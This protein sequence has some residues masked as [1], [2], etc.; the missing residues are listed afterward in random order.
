MFDKNRPLSNLKNA[1]LRDRTLFNIGDAAKKVKKDLSVPSVDE[2]YAAVR[3]LDAD[4][5]EDDVMSLTYTREQL[6][7]VC[8]DLFQEFR[9][10]F[11]GFLESVGLEGKMN[12]RKRWRALRW[13]AARWLAAARACR[14]SRRF[15]RRSCGITSIRYPVEK[16]RGILDTRAS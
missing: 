6:E 9:A 15:W 12:G 7:E 11:K 10:F 5:D 14:E 2:A 16:R 3:L 13:I 8:K 4:E 1:N